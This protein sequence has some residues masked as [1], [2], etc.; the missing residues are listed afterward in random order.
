MAW[1]VVPL[2]NAVSG[3][4]I[5][6]VAECGFWIDVVVAYDRCAAVAPWFARLVGG[7]LVFGVC[8]ALFLLL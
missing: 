1:V 7:I 2:A 3:S 8:G 5:V 6:A 4:G